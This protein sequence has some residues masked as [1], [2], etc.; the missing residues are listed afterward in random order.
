MRRFVRGLLSLFLVVVLLMPLS[1]GRGLSLDIDEKNKLAAKSLFI[2]HKA[3]RTSSMVEGL[4]I[5]LKVGKSFHA[6]LSSMGNVGNTEG[7]VKA[8]QVLAEATGAVG[9]ALKNAQLVSILA[10]GTQTAG[11]PP[12]LIEI[13]GE[14]YVLKKVAN[15]QAHGSYLIEFQKTLFQEGFPVP[16]IMASYSNEEGEVFVVEKYLKEGRNIKREDLEPKHLISIGKLAADIQG[17]F[18]RS[19]IEQNRHYRT[20]EELTPHTVDLKQKRDEL[21]DRV[22]DQSQTLKRILDQMVSHEERFRTNWDL[23]KSDFRTSHIYNDLTTYVGQAKGNILFN[24]EGHITGLYDFGY[25]QT[26]H[27]IAEFNQIYFV[28]GVSRLN[29]IS[30]DQLE[31]V[32]RGYQQKSVLPLNRNEILGIFE[33][34]RSRALEV[35]WRNISAHTIDEILANKDLLVDLINISNELEKIHDFVSDR[36]TFE[37]FVERMLRMGQRDALDLPLPVLTSI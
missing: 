7:I 12:L 11:N 37:A 8:Q 22:G 34:L 3:S 4:N 32:L 10:S 13:D 9:P 31:S 18:S 33:V 14:E 1:I 24:E 27:R 26:D 15:N 19:P 16:E 35:L 21:Q 6:L 5:N 17:A 25:A 23:F 28:G 2:E 29:G 30:L 20:R 36:S